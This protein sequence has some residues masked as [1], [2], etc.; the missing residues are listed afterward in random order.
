MT[1]THRAKATSAGNGSARGASRRAYHHGDLRRALIEAALALV[2]EGGPDALTVR[3]AARRAGVSP[4]APFRHFPDR[5]ALMTAVAEEASRRLSAE[6]AAGVAAAGTDDPFVRLHAVGAAFLRWAIRNPTHFQIVSLR[7]SI[8]FAGSA[9]LT[10]DTAA[11]QTLIHDLFEEAH[12]QG[13]LRS[14]Q[15]RLLKIVCRAFIYG[16]ARM[17]SDGQFP[18]WRVQPEETEAVIA[19]AQNLFTSLLENEPAKGAGRGRAP[20]AS[21]RTTVRRRRREA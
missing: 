1:T 10:A 17:H 6:I 12:A 3:E 7:D 15:L 16:L 19:Q 14:P 11:I 2:E 21:R 9:S 13:R 5:T 4:G 8:N 20:R 18:S